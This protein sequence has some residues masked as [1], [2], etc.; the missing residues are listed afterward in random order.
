MSSLALDLAEER[1]DLDCALALHAHVVA[2]LL[3]LNQA[4][5]FTLAKHYRICGASSDLDLDMY[6]DMYRD[7]WRA[8]GKR[9]LCHELAEH[10][11]DDPVALAVLA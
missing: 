6:L 8:S 5:L 10:M 3:K 9:D 7:G 1:F 2:R 11:A 4:D